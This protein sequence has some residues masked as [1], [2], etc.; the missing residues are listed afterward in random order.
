MGT[1]C[2]RRFG[3]SWPLWP[4]PDVATR[5]GQGL[6]VP[7]PDKARMASS[8]PRNAASSAGTACAGAGSRRN[9]VLDAT[10]PMGLSQNGQAREAGRAMGFGPQR[11]LPVRCH[12]ARRLRTG[13]AKPTEGGRSARETLPESLP[14][15]YEWHRWS[16]WR[17]EAAAGNGA[18]RQR[19]LPRCLGSEVA[20]EGEGL[21]VGRAVPIALARPGD[22]RRWNSP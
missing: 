7:F 1:S 8:R 3:S 14:I 13:G 4:A 11:G 10:V 18:G 2:E 17:P 16:Q 19:K 20:V 21:G 5:S 9:R 22:R 6:V 15:P 12:F